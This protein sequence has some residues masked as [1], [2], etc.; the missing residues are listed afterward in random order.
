MSREP[1]VFA[2][3]NQT[4][5]RFERADQRTASFFGGP[6]RVEFSGQP[7][8]PKPLHLIACL[9]S[10]H[11]P[12]LSK[13]FLTSLP[14]IYGMHYGGCELSYRVMSH[15]KLEILRMT[16][17]S[18]LEDWPYPNFPPLIPFVPLRLHDTPRPASYDEFTDRFPD[19][20]AE[21]AELI[22]AVPPP[23]TVGLSFWNDGDLDGVTIVFECDLK[24]KEVRAYNVTT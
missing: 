7:F 10:L 19:M 14:L 9:S 17:T 21:P 5:Y 18:S 24:N 12:A 15:C 6:L 13:P 8:G 1:L 11:I 22:V 2:F 23:A 3:H 16:P 20:P 4:L